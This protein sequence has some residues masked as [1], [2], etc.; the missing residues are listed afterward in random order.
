MNG[1]D[2]DLLM[3][4][5]GISNLNSPKFVLRDDGQTS[6]QLCSSPISRTIIALPVGMAM[7]SGKVTV[8]FGRAERT[9]SFGSTRIAQNAW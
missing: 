7:S 8:L 3:L 9:D 2:S 1:E 6:P 5:N 4:T